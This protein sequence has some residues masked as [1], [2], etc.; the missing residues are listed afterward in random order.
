MP[1]EQ[2]VR[3]INQILKDLEASTGSVVDSISLH[4]I[5]VTSIHSPRQ[6][7]ETSVVIELKRLPGRQWSDV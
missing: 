2:A 5:D 6:E 3:K 4:S 7:L 1:I